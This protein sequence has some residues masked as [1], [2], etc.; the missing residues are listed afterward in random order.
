MK[1]LLAVV[2]AFLESRT[3]RSNL[4]ALIRLLVVL[5]A[6][7]AAYSITFHYLMALEGQR[8]TWF[9]GIYWTLTVM[10]T[11]G[12]G[13]ITFHSDIG[14]VFSILVLITGVVFLL[15]LLPFTFIEF[16]YA[17]WMRAQA[18][19]RA[20]RELPADTRR[21]ILLTRYGPITKYLIKLLKRHW[22]RRWN[23]M[24][25]TFQSRLESSTIRKRIG[26][27]ESTRRPWWLPHAPTSSTPM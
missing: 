22:P 4:I 16:F 21:H 24:T 1:S 25:R 12:F 7:I 11:L 8:H 18:R 17:P 10:S 6:L 5:F 26:A 13:D 15:V 14:R 2:A 27:C 9:T 23:C 20:P 3:S 19:A